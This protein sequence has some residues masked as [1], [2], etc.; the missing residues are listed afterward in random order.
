[1]DTTTYRGAYF[2]ISKSNVTDWKNKISIYYKIDLI[3]V[4]RSKYIPI[5]VFSIRYILHFIKYISLVGDKFPSIKLAKNK[6]VF[7]ILLGPVLK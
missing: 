1:M 3:H 2:Q 7:G 5:C 6:K 4:I